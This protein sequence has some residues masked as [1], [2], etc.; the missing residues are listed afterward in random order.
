LPHAELEPS[1]AS[2]GVVPGAAYED[3]LTYRSF[4]VGA[5][6][7]DGKTFADDEMVTR[8]P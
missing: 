5:L 2:R 6:F 3:S 1:A 8:W 4:D 7:L